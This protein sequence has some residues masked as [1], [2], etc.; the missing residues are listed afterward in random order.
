VKNKRGRKTKD[1]RDTK[2]ISKAII[3]PDD[4]SDEDSPPKAVNDEEKSSQNANNKDEKKVK[5]EVLKKESKKKK[6]ISSGPL[7]ITANSEPVAIG[8]IGDLDP[9]IFNQVSDN[10]LTSPIHVLC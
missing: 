8:V 1:G 4:S 2:H 6:N 5:K 10:A 3:E 9:A 7:H